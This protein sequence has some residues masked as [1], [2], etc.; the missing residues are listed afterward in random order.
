[1]K[2]HPSHRGRAPPDRMERAMAEPIVS[3]MSAPEVGGG[4]ALKG[5]EGALGEGAS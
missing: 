2:M 3:W 1:M 4:A 5:T